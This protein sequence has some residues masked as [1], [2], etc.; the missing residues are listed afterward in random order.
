ML[1]FEGPD[2][3]SS[4]GFHEVEGYSIG[5]AEENYRSYSEIMI[6]TGKHYLIPGI[7]GTDENFPITQWDILLSQTQRKLNMMRPCR[8]N[9]KLSA[10][11]FL[12][13]QHDY[14]AAPFPP[15]GRRMLIFEGL[16]QR[17]S[18]DLHAA[19]GYSIGMAKENY[20]SYSGLLTS[21]NH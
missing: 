8:I 20:R 18:W 3:R 7:L 9:P 16:D 10:D 11:A 6:E 21:T 17:S 19:E 15:L 5:P 12:E 1:I 13:G 4:W 2:K 14:N